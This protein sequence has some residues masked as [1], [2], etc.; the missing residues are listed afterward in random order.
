[1]S[2]IY[3]EHNTH[4][5]K[6]EQASLVNRL[7]KIEGQVRGIQKMVEEDRYCIDVMVQISAVNAALKKVGFTMMEDHVN[8]CVADAIQ[9]GSGEESV[10][11]LMN[12]IKQFSK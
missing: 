4:R 5:T 1:M 3:E 2:N 8:H 7:K 10:H 6:Q 12:V 11:E 9:K